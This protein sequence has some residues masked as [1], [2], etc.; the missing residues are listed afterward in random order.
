MV[1][2][3][4]LLRFMV[5]EICLEKLRNADG[6]ARSRSGNRQ[7]PQ[8]HLG[9]IITEAWKMW[10]R[11]KWVT[12]RVMVCWLAT[13]YPWCQCQWK[14]APFRSTDWV[15]DA[16]VYLLHLP[17]TSV[18]PPFISSSSRD[19]LMI[20]SSL[21]TF[22]RIFRQLKGSY[23]LTYQWISKYMTM[24]PSCLGQWSYSSPW[25]LLLGCQICFQGLS[26]T[27]F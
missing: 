13:V 14:A 10:E 17:Y 15:N 23:L 24:P 26:A 11:D 27:F 9:V 4:L 1:Q 25:V 3:S 2:R 5:A 7:D 20:Q 21:I 6:L 22:L 8:G 12:K 19:V 16:F 18:C